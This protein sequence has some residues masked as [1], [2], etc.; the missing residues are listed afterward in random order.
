MSVVMD[1]CGVATAA[2]AGAAI[3]LYVSTMKYINEIVMRARAA[4]M[5]VVSRKRA[6]EPRV[7]V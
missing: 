5:A 1:Q 2:F 4:A 6:V 7:V 3:G